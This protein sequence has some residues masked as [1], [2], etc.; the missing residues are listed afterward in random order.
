MFCATSDKLV[1]SSGDTI[2][3]HFISGRCRLAATARTELKWHAGMCREP[4]FGL[5]ML[6]SHAKK[7]VLSP[8]CNLDEILRGSAVY[9]LR[10][11]TKHKGQW[12]EPIFF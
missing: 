6:G 11:H 8:C 3:V 1:I 10:A 12:P 2:E 4:P 9:N 5:V 7:A